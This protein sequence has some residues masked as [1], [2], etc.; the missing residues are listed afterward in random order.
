MSEGAKLYTNADARN[1]AAMP[2][3]DHRR[4]AS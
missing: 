2:F 1:T 3:N 4:C